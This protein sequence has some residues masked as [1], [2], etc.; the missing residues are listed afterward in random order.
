MDLSKKEQEKYLKE[1]GSYIV[2]LR[3]KRD[4]KQYELSDLLDIDVRVLRR[5]EKG[6]T[7]IQVLFLFKLAEVLDV[8]PTSF[9]SLKKER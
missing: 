5:I 9:I 2:K 1:L 3:E 7:N 6:E 8:S 4:L